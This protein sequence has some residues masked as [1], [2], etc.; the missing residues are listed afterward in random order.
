LLHHGDTVELRPDVGHATVPEAVEAWSAA[1][2]AC[3]KRVMISMLSDKA[4][5]YLCIGVDGVAYAKAPNG[6]KA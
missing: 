6:I 4:R 2:N 3:S 1:R 5:P